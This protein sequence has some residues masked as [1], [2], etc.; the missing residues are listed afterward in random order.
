MNISLPHLNVSILKFML[1]V[2]IGIA[3]WNFLSCS[4]GAILRELTDTKEIITTKNY[5]LLIS[6]AC[7]FLVIPLIKSKFGIPYYLF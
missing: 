3:P 5:I 6:I 2:F 1:S 7:V 4:A